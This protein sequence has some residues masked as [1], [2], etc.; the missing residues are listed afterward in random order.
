MQLIVVDLGHAWGG[1]Q[2]WAL[3][4]ARAWR[5]EGEPGR[6]LRVISPHVQFADVATVLTQVAPGRRGLVSASKA[7]QAGDIE[8]RVVLL[9]S[10][11][12]VYLTYRTI[13][14]PVIAW[15]HEPLI[16]PATPLWKRP[17]KLALRVAS[18]VRAER[19]IC[20][21]EDIRKSVPSV[22]ANKSDVIRNGVPDQ[23]IPR[24]QP[25]AA[26]RIAFI[27]R[28]DPV[29]RVH[30]L[31][32]AVARLRASLDRPVLLTIAGEGPERARLEQMVRRAGL[33]DAVSFLGQVTDVRAVLADCDVFVL[34]SVQEGLPLTI[35]EAFA[36]RRP[37]IGFAVPGVR[38][39]VR[40]GETGILCPDGDVD[41]LANALRSLADN[42]QLATTLSDRARRAW[43]AHHR[44]EDMIERSLLLLRDAASGV[45]A[46]GR[47]ARVAL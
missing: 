19:V 3:R 37:V 2:R 27:G 26:W 20:V 23:N 6:S 4:L 10:F 17:P 1:A 46:T 44:E 9:N 24:H 14:G 28:L 5:E 12:A 43:E 31:I 40:N 8:H 39:L 38:E 30:L 15:L 16:G 11:P 47:S 35:L 33:V 41:A 13:R 25:T 18:L 34:P 22:F 21:G 32:A 36:G 45:A 7:L 29:K 42:P